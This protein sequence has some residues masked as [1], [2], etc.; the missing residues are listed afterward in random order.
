MRTTVAC[1]RPHKRTPR[2]AVEIKRIQIDHCQ[3]R[4]FHTAVSRIPA[5]AKTDRQ[6][7]AAPGNPRSSVRSI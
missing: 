2:D 7:Y 5:K 3:L 4:I 1:P 6:I